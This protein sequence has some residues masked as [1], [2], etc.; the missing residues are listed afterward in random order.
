MSQASLRAQIVSV[1]NTVDD[2]GLVYD[3]SRY[4]NTWDKYLDKFKTTIDGTPQIRAWQV[5]YSALTANQAVLKRQVDRQYTFTITGYLRVR[6]TDAGDL[7]TPSE[8]E[9]AALTEDVL[10]ALDSD[11]VLHSAP[12]HLGYAGVTNFGYAQFGG[13]VCHIVEIDQPVREVFTVGS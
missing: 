10:N 9:F 13:V 6:D 1:L 7:F 12:N 3:R 8:T 11:P 5:T 4:A 2:I